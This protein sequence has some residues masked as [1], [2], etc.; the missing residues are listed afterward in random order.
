MIKMLT[1][2][3][4][5]ISSS[6]VCLL[7]KCVKSCSHFLSKNISVYAI[8]NDQSFNN[9]LTNAIVSFEQVGP[10]RHLSKILSFLL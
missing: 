7:K 6:Q 2:L 9:M 3:V 1:I 4:S 8:F 10:D 5:T